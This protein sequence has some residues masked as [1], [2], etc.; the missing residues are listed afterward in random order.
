MGWIC[1]GLTVCIQS[2]SYS[3]PF[4]CFHYSSE[5]VSLLNPD[6]GHGYGWYSDSILVDGIP[7]ANTPGSLLYYS[8]SF[9]TS[10]YQ[11]LSFRNLLVFLVAA[12]SFL[13]LFGVMGL[14]LSFN[15]VSGGRK[16]NVFV[17]V[18]TLKWNYGSQSYSCCLK[19]LPSKVKP[20]Y[21]KW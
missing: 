15:G 3:L 5:P 10:V 21:I 11:L 14:Y 4:H 12:S 17:C 13:V 6:I 20:V 2:F 18:I 19:L 1:R 7:L 9:S 8:A 16:I